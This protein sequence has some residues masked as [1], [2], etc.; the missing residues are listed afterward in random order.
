[1]IYTYKSF[2][3]IRLNLL[4]IYAI[5]RFHIIVSKYCVATYV[6]CILSNLYF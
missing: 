6:I 3:D 2:L 1:M 4:L 5:V